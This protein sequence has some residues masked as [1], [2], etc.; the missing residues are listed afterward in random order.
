[1]TTKIAFNQIDGMDSSVR[2][3]GAV[4]DN[5]TDDGAAIQEAFAAAQSRAVSWPNTGT[6]QENPTS[7]SIPPV[8][9]NSGIYRTS[10]PLTNSTPYNFM[11]VKGNGAIV[12]DTTLR[13]V[14]E[15]FR[16]GYD[17]SMDGMEI[18]GFENQ[19][20][21]DNNNVNQ[22]HHWITNCHFHKPSVAVIG[23]NNNPQ[24]GQI[25]IERC[26]VTTYDGAKFLY[27]PTTAERI[28]FLAIR[29]CWIQPTL[30]T[31]NT[32]N[33][34]GTFMD[35]RS[36]SVLI[37]NMTG[38]PTGS[39]ATNTP[40]SWMRFYGTNLEVRHSNFGPELTGGVTALENF[41]S[42]TESTDLKTQ[43]SISNTR[44]GTSGDRPQV[45]FFKIP[46]T[47]TFRALNDDG[48]NGGMEYVDATDADGIAESSGIDLA[49]LKAFAMDGAV[50]VDSWDYLI[51]KQTTMGT[52]A[53]LGYQ[54][55]KAAYYDQVG[56]PYVDKLK[57]SD[58]L[59]C[60][61]HN[62]GTSTKI[63][64]TTSGVD[65]TDYRGVAVRTR[66]ASADGSSY[67]FS[68]NDWLDHAMIG[69][70]ADGDDL[71]MTLL[72]EIEYTPA[73]QGSARLYAG[74][75]QNIKSYPLEIGNKTY[76]IPFVYFNTTNLDSSGDLD[77]LLMGALNMANGDAV[78]FKRMMVVKGFKQTD[79]EQIT[80]FQEV[81]TTPSDIANTNI[82]WSAGWVKGDRVLNHA[83][84]AEIPYFVCSTEQTGTTVWASGAVLT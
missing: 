14:S 42:A 25:T 55:I 50:M 7:A 68:W 84:A 22:S 17:W 35:L 74:P 16:F 48:V 47:I 78:S 53:G 6:G 10:V 59:S 71:S 60:G 46:N 77:R 73:K 82:N 5:S 21:I 9:F 62:Q 56:V 28:D 44:L 64:A 20:I 67:Q 40:A 24:S 63:N 72:L 39:L 45:R 11:Q 13:T 69:A 51:S 38:V 27:M 36:S 75:A 18:R 41:A 2:D 8:Y 15:A 29:D 83:A 32:F 54:L 33:I 76:A 81:I 4:G 1:M 30:N 57:V 65:T 58:I 19:I 61:A 3:H 31:S 70:S 26:S 34:D 37:D 43:I 66:T 49:N 80:A 52:H 12:A 79:I 23:F